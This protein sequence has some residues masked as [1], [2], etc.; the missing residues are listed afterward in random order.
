MSDAASAAARLPYHHGN[1]R[2]ALVEAAH[3]LAR[4]GG[5]DAIVVREA[6]RRVG[7]SHNAAYR[8][9]PDRESLLAAVA[10]RCLAEL[11]ALME[12]LM[13]EAGAVGPPLG[14]ARA[15]LRATGR[16]YIEFAHTEPGLFH[17]AFSGAG[18]HRGQA[19]GQASESAPA[20]PFMVL[21]SALDELDGAGGIGRGARE[22]AEHVAWS[23]VHGFS[24]LSID[25]PLR[26]LSDEERRT[27]VEEL[28]TAIELGLTV[29]H[30]SSPS[31][32]S[33]R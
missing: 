23:T 7:V 17:T 33:R 9:F 15:R 24:M 22:S 16:A 2:E 30:P 32:R 5:P 6:S 27:A 28:L 4:A 18:E 25:G 21:T 11:A 3:Q 1:L 29:P 8:H 14:R 26:G 10:E 31:R 13:S 19:P 12:R 20:G